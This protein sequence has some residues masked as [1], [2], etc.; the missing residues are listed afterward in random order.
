[1][2]K[3]LTTKIFIMKTSFFSSHS[4]IKEIYGHCL[5]EYLLAVQPDTD[6]YDKILN[7]KQLFYDEYK[8]QEIIKKN[9]QLIVA[10]FLVK[11]A[12]EETLSR[13]IQRICSSQQ[14]F[15]LTLNNYS[16]VPQNS[17][18]LRVQNEQPFQKLSAALKELNPYI[19]SCVC[20]PMQFTS[21][22]HIRIADDL[23]EN[24]YVNA[25]KKYAQKTFH[26][27]FTVNELQL[28][29]RENE[30]ETYK[31]ISVFSL[32][33]AEDTCSVLSW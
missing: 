1:M 27:S 26:E 2:L 33:P 5:S 24:I 3:L 10:G 17:I 9:P 22:L 12:M 32:Q 29:K 16:G 19:T 7:E 30:Y 23:P 13:W 20:P 31:T 28:L 4:I 6:V 15:I 21:R 11:V 8:V 18:F 14:R 25:L